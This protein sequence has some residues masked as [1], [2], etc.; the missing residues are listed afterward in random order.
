MSAKRTGVSRGENR[1]EYEADRASREKPDRDAEDEA[2]GSDIPEESRPEAR[3]GETPS[4][5]LAGLESELLE[6]QAGV[7]ELNREREKCK[8]V[9]EDMRESFEEANTCIEDYRADFDALGARRSDLDA[10]FQTK[11]EMVGTAAKEIVPVYEEAVDEH[12]EKLTALERE[13]EK[14]EH[15]LRQARSASEQA[16]EEL[17]WTHREFSKTKEF[18][19]GTRRG[20]ESMADLRK[21][22]EAAEDEPKPD[23]PSMYVRLKDLEEILCSTTLP[24]PDEYTDQID[25]AWKKLYL[26]RTKALEVQE[27]LAAAQ[28][29]LDQVRAERDA[30]TNR[31]QQLI[32]KETRDK[33]LTSDETY[34]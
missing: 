14:A 23:I 12:N 17:E 31:R 8:A 25:S 4:K 24:P 10:Y 7:E 3:V 28:A 2:Y 15:E 11:H 34:A 13:V 16:Q 33:L 30:L 20:V 32:L 22:I 5:L 21:E 18:K 19:A 26:A 27:K 6:K 1:K 9:L 29:R